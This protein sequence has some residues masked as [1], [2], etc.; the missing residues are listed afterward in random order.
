MDRTVA[1]TTDARRSILRLAAEIMH[2]RADVTEQDHAVALALATIF[3]AADTD[4]TRITLGT[5]YAVVARA[6]GML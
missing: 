1:A 6:A 3:G 5:G 4:G 2:D